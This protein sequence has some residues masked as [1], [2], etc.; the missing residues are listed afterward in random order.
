MSPKI[1]LVYFDTKGLAEPSRL[2]L[3]MAGVN[4]EDYRYPFQVINASKHLYNK[5]EFDSDKKAGL[6]EKS[7]GKLPFLEIKESDKKVIMAY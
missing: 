5:P 2:L 7:M 1:K 4:F 6:F 3:K